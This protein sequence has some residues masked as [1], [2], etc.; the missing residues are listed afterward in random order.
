MNNSDNPDDKIAAAQDWIAQ[1]GDYE[2]RRRDIFPHN[3]TAIFDAL[4]RSGVETVTM[5]FDGYGDSGQVDEIIAAGGTQ[6]LAAI[7]VQQLQALWNDPAPAAT[8][9]DLRTAIEDLGYAL[10][11]RSHCGWCNNEGAYGEFVF[12]VQAR[13]I[14][15]DFN[16]RYVHAESY[17]H[18]F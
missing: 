18:D 2:N 3:R 16:E 10:L 1:A 11:E 9:V 17:W 12:D 8:L 14:T 7:E 5:T 4:E 13:T 15:L 6:D